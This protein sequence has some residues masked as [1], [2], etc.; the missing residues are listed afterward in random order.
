[1]VA[2]V[3]KNTKVNKKNLTEFK[4][5]LPK[6]NLVFSDNQ[7]LGESRS[8]LDF[9]AKIKAM[10]AHKIVFDLLRM[11]GKLIELVGHIHYIHEHRRN[12]VFTWCT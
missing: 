2:W 9:K 3:I 8:I 1:M 10:K 7:W 4:K 11:V 5:K 12:V 6:H